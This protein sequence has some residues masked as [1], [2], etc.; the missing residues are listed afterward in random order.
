MRRVP[1]NPFS[2]NSGTLYGLLAGGLADK[3]DN[4]RVYHSR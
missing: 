1:F 3:A 4:D 2:R